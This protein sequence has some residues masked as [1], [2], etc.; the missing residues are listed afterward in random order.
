MRI[1]YEESIIEWNGGHY[2][3]VSLPNGSMDVFS[4]AWEK[5]RPTAIDFIDS[6]I[7]YLDEGWLQ[8]AYNE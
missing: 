8:E 5:I 3:N 2:G 7:I 1:N 6:A 4:F